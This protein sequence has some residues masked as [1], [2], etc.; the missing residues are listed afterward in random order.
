MDIS[1]KVLLMLL[2]ARVLIA[3]VGCRCNE[4]NEVVMNK[5]IW[6]FIDSSYTCSS[7]R[8]NAVNTTVE[9]DDGERC[10]GMRDT[11]TDR[12]D[13]CVHWDYLGIAQMKRRM[14]WGG[15]EWIRIYPSDYYGCKSDGIRDFTLID[16]AD[17][18]VLKLTRQ[19]DVIKGND[20]HLFAY[21]NKQSLNRVMSIASEMK[22]L[23]ALSFIY[24]DGVE[25]DDAITSSVN[26]LPKNVKV[27]VTMNMTCKRH[28]RQM[29]ELVKLRERVV[30]LKLISGDNVKCDEFVPKLRLGQYLKAFKNLGV[31]I[32]FDKGDN[33]WPS[34]RDLIRTLPESVHAVVIDG[35]KQ[36]KEKVNIADI[37]FNESVRI[38]SVRNACIEYERR[39]DDRTMGHKGHPSVTRFVAAT[40]CP[41]GDDVGAAIAAMATGG[42]LKHVH[43][44]APEIR[45]KRTHI[46]RINEANIKYLHFDN[47]VPSSARENNMQIELAA[48]MSLLLDEKYI[49]KRTIALLR[50]RPT[51]SIRRLAVRLLS[52][53]KLKSTMEAIERQRRSI[54]ELSLFTNRSS[55]R[56]SLGSETIASIAKM[57][58]LVSLVLH[59]TRAEE[60]GWRF[61]FRSLRRLKRL[62]IDAEDVKMLAASKAGRRLLDDLYI[63]SIHGVVDDDV[64]TALKG[65]KIELITADDVSLSCRGIESLSMSKELKEINVSGTMDC[66]RCRV[67]RFGPPELKR[68]R[69]GTIK[70][71]PN[72]LIAF[73]MAKKLE[74]IEIKK[75]MDWKSLSQLIAHKN[76]R[77]VRVE[78][79]KG[80]CRHISSDSGIRGSSKLRLL[81]VSKIKS[82]KCIY[83]IARTIGYKPT[84]RKACL[85]T[86]PDVYHQIPKLVGGRGRMV[87]EKIDAN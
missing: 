62:E 46:N 8:S 17:V 32:L 72:G 53:A 38:L 9:R 1:T 34:L 10:M 57:K 13:V 18:S 84:L 21:L 52:G 70:L 71:H 24:R 44:S 54:S 61:V 55:T 79:I 2:M 43:L 74:L 75:G 60:R 80:D 42:D 37:V 5:N 15:L 87:F 29:S 16:V 45:L 59:N 69:I 11:G 66:S 31:L 50:R 65:R 73:D 25:L 6:N 3:S 36:L 86:T 39:N 76:I 77:V 82:K 40:A 48:N 51:G 14:V 63:L 56:I 85:K 4:Q 81:H 30:S 20:T 19:G 68:A 64:A 83:A 33:D 35:W 78:N 49:D 26:S 67:A 12:D 7:A 41:L 58:N 28:V 23:K 27:H 22:S 47:Y